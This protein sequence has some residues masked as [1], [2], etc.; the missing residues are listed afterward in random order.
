MS[1]W[2]NNFFAYQC[3]RCCL[4]EAMLKDKD[5][6]KK[7]REIKISDYCCACCGDDKDK[8]TG[9]DF[10]DKWTCCLLWFPGC[11]PCGT[12]RAENKAGNLEAHAGLRFCMDVCCPSLCCCGCCA[13]CI[14]ASSQENSDPNTVLAYMAKGRESQE[15]RDRVALIPIAP[16]G[17]FVL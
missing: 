3:C 9:C 4:M 11:Q 7:Y 10:I 2:W 14:Y 17:A 15:K 12:Q 13:A 8:V 1:K 5:L 6:Q 16:P